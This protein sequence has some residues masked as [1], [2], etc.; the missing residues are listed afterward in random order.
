MLGKYHPHFM[1]E[2]KET[3][4]F[5]PRS[6]E[7]SSLDLLSPSCAVLPPLSC[8]SFTVSSQ[9]PWSY[10]TFWPEDKTVLLDKEG[11][12]DR[13]AWKIALC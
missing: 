4:G 11:E 3:W 6:V 12:V 7:L 1:Y 13:M 10:F 9:T 8:M 5:Q 2:Q